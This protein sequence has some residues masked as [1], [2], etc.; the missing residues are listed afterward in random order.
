[1]LPFGVQTPPPSFSTEETLAAVRKAAA[2]LRFAPRVDRIMHK[3]EVDDVCGWLADCR[4]SEMFWHGLDDKYPVRQCYIAKL[5]I[6]VDDDDFYV[7]VSLNLP[8]LTGGRVISFW[9]W[10]DL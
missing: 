7:K 2:T 9:P 6:E 3:V 4:A 5:H 8:G 10:K 1:M